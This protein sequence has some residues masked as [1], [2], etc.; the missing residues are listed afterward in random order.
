MS[1]IKAP[2][3]LPRPLVNQLL[4]EAQN[5]P[6]AEVCGLIGKSRDG[7]HCYPITNVAEDPAHQF[8]LDGAELFN[9][10]R[11]MSERGEKPYAIYHSH[12]TAPAYPSATDQRWAAYPDYLYL[13]ISLDITGVLQIRGFQLRGE[14]IDEIA[15]EI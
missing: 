5:S 12:P 7:S 3:V 13:I 1:A 15:L 9:A 14:Q 4:T 10:I 8:L 2:V 11:K 6:G